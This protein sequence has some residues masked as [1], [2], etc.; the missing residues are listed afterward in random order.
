MAGPGFA[1]GSRSNLCQPRTELEFR[2]VSF[3]ESVI[4][5]TCM[6]TKYVGVFC[7]NDKC[8]HF[9]VLS[10]H[11]VDD[12]SKLGTDLDPTTS[13]KGI[14][15]T[16]CGSTCHYAHADVAHSMSPDGSNPRFQK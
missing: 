12:P 7:G 9:I 13:E 6:V 5:T 3:C 4:R 14:M 2:S 15:C 11:P 16:K 8:R 10:S 1:F